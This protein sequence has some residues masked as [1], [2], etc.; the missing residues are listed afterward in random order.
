MSNSYQ[1]KKE[2][3][4]R[5]NFIDTAELAY[6]LTCQD[7]SI[8]GS[9]NT[10]RSN[11]VSIGDS[12]SQGDIQVQ[13][14]NEAVESGVRDHFGYQ[15]ID[16]LTEDILALL[17][18]R[19]IAI[20]QDRSDTSKLPHFRDSST[21]T[22]SRT[23]MADEARRLEDD[24][25]VK[26]LQPL[27]WPEELT[28]NVIF[29]LRTYIAK[30]LSMYKGVYYHNC[31][32]AHHVFISANKLLDLMLCEHDWMPLKPS[33]EEG[34]Q[35]SYVNDEDSYLEHFQKTAMQEPT[36]KPPKPTY[37]IKK[38]YLIQFGFLFSALVHD[39]DHKGV[40]NRQLV[41]ESDELAI[42]YNDQSVAEQRS[43]AVAFTLLME[44]EFNALRNVLF[45]DHHGFFQFR[46]NVIDLVLCT[47]ISS[48]E[49]VQI[50]KS[51]F[52]EAFGD[53]KRYINRRGSNCTSHS[54][55]TDAEDAT[56]KEKEEAERKKLRNAWKTNP[57]D[58]SLADP[59]ETNTL[60]KQFFNARAS[61]AAS[62]PTSLLH[63]N[64]PSSIIESLSNLSDDSIYSS[65]SETDS[66]APSTK[67]SIEE[68]MRPGSA[69]PKNIRK[70]HSRRFTEPNSVL[71]S[72]TKKFHFRLGIRRALDLT[73]STIEAYEHQQKDNEKIP[74]P[75]CP[76][77][78]KAI[79]VLEQMLKAAD[80]AANMQVST[81]D[82]IV[83]LI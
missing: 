58:P 32:H 14:A 2:D 13:T 65:S 52:K 79:V 24:K 63:A 48:P 83:F 64:E 1:A 53:K 9:K 74:D 21:T 78:L 72:R 57:A 6:D 35:E 45:Q 60:V 59:I 82:F 54:N 43:L 42:M 49:R 22:I 34:R 20:L 75:D 11:D 39:V 26:E 41:L 55:E 70:H 5:P 67:G 62:G 81:I 76:N 73:G 29:Q 10:A 50:V 16:D 56:K 37:G 28:D 51:K 36:P 19:I 4:I 17:L 12:S 47:D 18:M 23:I 61:I 44:P 25:L 31:E 3:F 7:W 80:V 30:V 66:E 38:N 71:Q 33:E 15:L 77:D 68:M 69:D 8:L 27:D 46:S 40:S